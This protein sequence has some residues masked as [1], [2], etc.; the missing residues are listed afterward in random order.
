MLVTRLL[1]GTKFFLRNVDQSYIPYIRK[2]C[3]VFGAP[4][5]VCEQIYK[6]KP[7]QSIKI[8]DIKADFIIPKECKRSDSLLVYFH[9]GAYVMGSPLVYRLFA[10][11]LAEMCSI[12]VLLPSYNLAPEVKFPGQ[13]LDAIDTYKFVNKEIQPKHIFVGGDSAG[14]NLTLSSLLAVTSPDKFQ[15][16]L[17]LLLNNT[18]ILKTVKD[19]LDNLPDTKVFRGIIGLS[20]WVNMAHTDKDMIQK[21]LDSNDPLLPPERYVLVAELYTGIQSHEPTWEK[22]THSPFLSPVYASEDQVKRL[23]DI[24]IH[25][26][27]ADMLIEDVRELSKLFGAK[28]NLRVWDNLFHVFMIFPPTLC[29]SSKESM[30]GISEFISKLSN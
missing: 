25:A 20:P 8:G 11:R 7:I 23:P 15:T 26:G 9:G 18:S 14:A 3:K 6:I 12:P 29:P 28:C 10:C 2:A 19:K 4:R 21:A 27:T 5:V 22:F 30:E 24:L 1:C 13:I 16:E 17:K